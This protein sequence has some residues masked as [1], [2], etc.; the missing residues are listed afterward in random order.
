MFKPILTLIIV[1]LAILSLVGVSEAQERKVVVMVSVD[2]L[3]AIIRDL[4]LD[5]VEIVTLIPEGAEPH[6]YQVSPETLEEARKADLFVFTGHLVFEKKLASLLPEIPVLQ[7]DEENY[8]GKYKLEILELPDGRRNLH[9]YWLYP[10][11]A[12]VIAKAVVDKLIEI[13]PVNAEKYLKKLEEFKDRV[14]R[15]KQYITKIAEFYAVKNM[16]VIIT[17]PGEQYVAY[18]MGFTIAGMLSKG[19]GVFAS[20]AELSE[21]KSKLEKGYAKIIMA[22]DVS[23]MLNVGKFIEDLSRETKTPIAYVKLIGSKDLTY[24]DLLMYNI[25]VIIGAFS[26]TAMGKSAVQ[27]NKTILPTAIYALI[28]SLV[29]VIV[30]E[31]YLLYVRSKYR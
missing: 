21:I 30:V 22:S 5:N 28:A 13:D 11:N 2:S 27:S 23:R 16:S 31:S 3:A 10:D 17:F 1:L 25:G 15:I 24:S 12:L 9:A 6:S 26:S 18:T 4:S 14:R 19:E 7:I 8:F 20:G 29:I